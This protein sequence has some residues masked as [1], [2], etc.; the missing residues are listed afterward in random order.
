PRYH[1]GEVVWVNPTRPA[2]VGMDALLMHGRAE[3]ASIAVVLGVLESHAK[4]MLVL[5]QYGSGIRREFE[6]AQWRAVHVY[7]RD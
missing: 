6:A 7:G 5:S 3:T 4:G 2:S 1:A